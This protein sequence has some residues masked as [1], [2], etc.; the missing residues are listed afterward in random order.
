MYNAELAESYFDEVMYLNFPLVLFW[1]IFAD[2]QSKEQSKSRHYNSK[3]CY[4][5]CAM[6]SH[7]L[8][9]NGT[10]QTQYWEDSI[11]VTMVVLPLKGK[12]S[13]KRVIKYIIPRSQDPPRVIHQLLMLAGDVETNPGPGMIMCA[14]IDH[15]LL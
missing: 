13:H 10:V 14:L 9:R 1:W 4:D 12:C 8:L 5:N 2:Q 6:C 3:H 7:H 15:V 11:P